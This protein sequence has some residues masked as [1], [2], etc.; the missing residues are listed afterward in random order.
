MPIGR[1]IPQPPAGVLRIYQENGIP[2]G[3]D[4]LVKRTALIKAREDRTPTYILYA[5]DVDNEITA[6]T[7]DLLRYKS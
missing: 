4:P 2:H 7:Y 1:W 5:A 3:A 6:L